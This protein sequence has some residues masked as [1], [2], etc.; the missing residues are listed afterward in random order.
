MMQFL[1]GLLGSQAGSSLD[2]VS[3]IAGA[4]GP[5][6][7]S[8]VLGFLTDT[9]NS[10][11]TDALGA[12]GNLGSVAPLLNGLLGGLSPQQGTAPAPRISGGG[13]LSRGGNIPRISLPATN[14]VSIK[15]RL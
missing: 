4:Q 15:G 12:D 7:G 6:Q 3:G 1:Q 11:I 9:G 5:T 13:G 14:P 8:G 2:A 10:S